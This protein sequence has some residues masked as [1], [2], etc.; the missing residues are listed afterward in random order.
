MAYPTA[1]NDQITDAVSQTNV[2]VVGESPALALASQMLSV[3]HAH[4]L[5]AYNAV[6]HQHQSN[7]VSLSGT[8]DSISQMNTQ[9]SQMFGDIATKM[10]KSDQLMLESNRSILDKLVDLQAIL[11]TKPKPYG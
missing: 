5:M 4:A 2:K 10:A 9:Q 8:V 1:V 3:C 11:Q 6:S 7:I